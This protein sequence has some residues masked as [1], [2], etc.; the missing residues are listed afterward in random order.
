MKYMYIH[1]CTFSSLG[2]ESVAIDVFSKMLSLAHTH[3]HTHTHDHIHTCKVR[4]H[5][6]RG[7]G[8]SHAFDVGSLTLPML[9]FLS[10]M[11]PL[12]QNY[13]ISAR[14]PVPFG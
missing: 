10:K 4:S 6:V 2:S 7:V 3:T 1:T 9:W 14:V 12:L 13:L 5:R 8:L 11:N